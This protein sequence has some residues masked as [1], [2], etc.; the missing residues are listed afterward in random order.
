MVWLWRVNIMKGMRTPQ[1]I[2]MAAS[3]HHSTEAISMASGPRR[4]NPNTRKPLRMVAKP[5]GMQPKNIDITGWL[6]I[7]RASSK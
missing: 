3:S 7:R 4:V 2:A 5:I 6:K 1:A